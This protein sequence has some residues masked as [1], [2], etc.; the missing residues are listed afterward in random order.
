MPAPFFDVK[1]GKNPPNPGLISFPVTDKSADKTISRQNADRKRGKVKKAGLEAVPG[2]FFWKTPNSPQKGWDKQEISLVASNSESMG[3]SNDPTE[4]RRRFF[5]VSQRV[6]SQE[7]CYG[8]K[9]TDTGR[10]GKIPIAVSK[11]KTRRREKGNQA[12][13]GYPH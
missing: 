6:P 5:Q 10:G 9:D 8:S 1:V 13:I 11:G 12:I 7:W 3:E 2:C 4:N